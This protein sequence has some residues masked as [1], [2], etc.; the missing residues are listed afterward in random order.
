VSA[1]DQ[2]QGDAPELPGL[3]A[4]VA[5]RFRRW[6]PTERLV[7]VDQ[8]EAMG[9]AFDS[10]GPQRP[11][12]C[13]A[14]VLSYLFPAL[15][16]REHDG[17]DLAS[18]DYLAHLA[19]VV[20]E[21]DE[22]PTSNE[23]G[24]RVA[25]GEL[26]ETEALLR[27]GREWY[28]YPVRASDDPIS[29]GTSPT[30]VARAIDLGS[31][32]RLVSLPVAAR[33]QDGTVQ[34]TSARWEALLD[35]LA[36]NVVEWR[37]HAIFNYES[38]QLLRPDDPAYRPGNLRRPDCVARI[39]RDDWGVGHFVGLAGL[40]KME[41]A[42]WLLLFDTYKERGFDGYQPQP[43]ELMRRGLVRED[44]RGGGLL[45]VLPRDHAQA[46]TRA[47]RSVGLTPRIWSNGSPEPDD[48]VWRFPG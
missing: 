25:S 7:L 37:W 23:I 17:H 31:G 28:R 47:I 4:G 35:R 9:Q 40:W 32:E 27:H 20:V 15:G 36:A 3:R 12:T 6:F 19:A 29:T 14:Y 45:L 2:P 33:L 10:L 41:D 48:W 5:D 22:I 38:D 34:L 13:G 24:R 43:A 44:G 42:W 11:A 16:M 8:A 39:P 26:T 1:N 46:A 30:G 18:E 21:A